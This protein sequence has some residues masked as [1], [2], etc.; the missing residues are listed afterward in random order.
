LG[1]GMQ[2]EV[3]KVRSYKDDMEYAMKVVESAKMSNKIFA[4]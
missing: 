1:A 3:I 2:G 4:E